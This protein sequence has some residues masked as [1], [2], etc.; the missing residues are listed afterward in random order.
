VTKYTPSNAPAPLKQA[1]AESSKD[2]GIPADL[3]FGIWLREAGGEYPNPYVNSSGYGGLFGTE[4]W[5]GSTLSQALLAGGI[6]EKGFEESGGNVAEA[7]SYYNSGQLTGGYTSV[8]DET[9]FGT[10]KG[11]H[12]SG[13]GTD[14]PS[15]IVKVAKAPVN[16]VKNAAGGLADGIKSLGYQILFGLMGTALLVVGLALVAWAI[17]GRVGA[18]GIIGMAQ[19]QMRIGQASSRLAETTRA[20]GVRERQADTRI[21]GQTSQRELSARRLDVQE[22]TQRRQE[23]R[24]AANAA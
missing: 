24:E 20:S 23:E 13:G 16:A 9:T 18:P 17:M 19:T 7:L 15:D 3:L 5:Q 22:Q 14:L 10:I 11:Y 6:L 12:R 4:D 2:Y 1:I 8:P 21:A